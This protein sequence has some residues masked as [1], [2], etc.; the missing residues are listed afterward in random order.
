MLSSEVLFQYFLFVSVSGGGER[1]KERKKREKEEKRK[2]MLTI[3]LTT[4]SPTS[5]LKL[6]TLQNPQISKRWQRSNTTDTFVLY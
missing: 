1:K 3:F 6:P 4:L 2:R 5:S